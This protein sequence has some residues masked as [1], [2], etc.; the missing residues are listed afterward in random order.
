MSPP[1]NIS[2]T[3]VKMFAIAV[4]AL[5]MVA[6]TA[7]THKR[8]VR[9]RCVRVEDIHTPRRDVPS[10]IDQVTLDL[11]AMFIVTSIE[12]VGDELEETSE[13]TAECHA[14]SIPMEND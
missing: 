1:L 2:Y 7:E 4:F 8:R 6:G 14:C 3:R 12:T 13:P 5:R 11:T 10:G 9:Q